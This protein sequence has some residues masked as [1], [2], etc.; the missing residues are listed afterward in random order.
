MNGNIKS[1]YNELFIVLE[2]FL[3]RWGSATHISVRLECLDVG[4]R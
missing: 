4:V 2:L 3:M 1:E